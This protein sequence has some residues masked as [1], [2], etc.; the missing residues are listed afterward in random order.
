MPQCLQ[1]FPELGEL[2]T[3]PEGVFLQIYITTL[4]K[5]SL[6]AHQKSE[7]S[8]WNLEEITHIQARL[9]SSHR[10]TWMAPC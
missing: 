2:C 8:D 1:I 9:S 5:L 3:V 6:G 4:S 10:S 7:L